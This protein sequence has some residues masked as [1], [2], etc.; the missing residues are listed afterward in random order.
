MKPVLNHRPSTLSPQLT[1]GGTMGYVDKA[2]A[3]KAAGFLWRYKM[4]LYRSMEDMELPNHRWL[5]EEIERGVCTFGEI[6]INAKAWPPI[7][8]DPKY[9]EFFRAVV[10]RDDTAMPGLVDLGRW[11]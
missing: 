7:T 8:Q 1:E 3:E 9:P 5:A 4:A 10:L 11:R 2:S 6:T